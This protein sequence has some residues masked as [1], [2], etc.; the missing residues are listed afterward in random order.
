MLWDSTK[1]IW[2]VVFPDGTRV[3][4]QGGATTFY[5]NRGDNGT[6]GLHQVNSNVIMPTGKFC[7][8]VLDATDAL[9]T[10]CTTMSELLLPIS[11]RQAK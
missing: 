1:Q 8:K 5:R 6:V 4:V 9:Q 7:R 2:R 10:I 3:P 11:Y